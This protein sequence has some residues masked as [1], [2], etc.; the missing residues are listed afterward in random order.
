MTFDEL[1][2]T[3]QSQRT[4]FKLTIDSD[5]LLKEV[6]RNKKHFAS[7]I[8]WRD[9]REVGIAL[10]ASGF[11]AYWGLRNSLWPLLLVAF[12]VA[13]IGIFMIIDRVIQK[14]KLPQFAESLTGCIESSLAQVTHQI[15][16]LKNVLWWYFLPPSIGIAVFFAYMIYA[17]RD[18][19]VLVCIVSISIFAAIM[20]AYWAGYRLN[21]YCVRKDLIPRRKE[22]EQLLTALTNG[23]HQ[24]A[25]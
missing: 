5:M 25:S 4:G 22:L 11:L 23:D 3:W 20:L 10:P 24:S 2:K 7:A 8:F 16:L 18:L 15:W 19:G 14:R 13:G 17:L 9:V 1:K 12:A 6:K 21:Q